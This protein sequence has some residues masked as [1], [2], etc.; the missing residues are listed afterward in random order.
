MPPSPAQ[1]AILVLVCLPEQ[2]RQQIKHVAFEPL[3]LFAKQHQEIAEKDLRQWTVSSHFGL[4]SV[5]L[6]R[7]PEVTQLGTRHAP[8][9]ARPNLAQELRRNVVGP[10]TEHPL[11]YGARLAVATVR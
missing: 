9:T 2:L 5:S 6:L 3:C 4:E 7:G 11:G 1:V 8:L 10:I